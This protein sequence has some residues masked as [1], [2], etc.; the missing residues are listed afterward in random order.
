MFGV[1][2]GHGGSFC[3]DYVKENLLSKIIQD[4]K[5]QLASQP[6]NPAPSATNNSISSISSPEIVFRKDSTIK[7]SFS[8][9]DKEF[10]KKCSECSSGNSNNSSFSGASSGLSISGNGSNNNSGNNN[11]N[12]GNS[13]S[14]LSTPEK[15]KNFI[16]KHTSIVNKFSQ[17]NNIHPKNFN[18]PIKIGKS[19]ISVAS[20]INLSSNSSGSSNSNSSGPSNSNSTSNNPSSNSTSIVAIPSSTAPSLVIKHSN[21][22]LRKT[23]TSPG[24]QQSSHSPATGSK[25]HPY[26][27]IST[28][29][30]LHSE[31][32]LFLSG[33]EDP[34]F[35]SGSTANTAILKCKYSNTEKKCVIEIIDCNVGDSRCFVYNQ[36]KTTQLSQDHK[37]H[38]ESEKSR[39]QG[40]GGVVESGRVNGMLAVSRAFGDFDFKKV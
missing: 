6:Q 25:F 39:I 10:L 32:V 13:N 20:S 23:P 31:D 33:E 38:V 30:T 28:N 27:N 35:Y 37:P 21:P 40:A 2:D 14:I 24:P 17:F 18:S 5:K 11:Q 4:E 36:G 3:V 15:K 26:N 12:G 19:S 9:L 34:I 16:T 8:D 1:F 29:K 7:D 22:F